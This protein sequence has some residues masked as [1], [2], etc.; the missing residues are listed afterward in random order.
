[1]FGQQLVVNVSFEVLVVIVVDKMFQ[2]EEID[3]RQ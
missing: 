3:S 1:V 2:R